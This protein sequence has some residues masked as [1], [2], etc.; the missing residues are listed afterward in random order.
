M[1]GLTDAQEWRGHYLSLRASCGEIKQ[2]AR[3]TDV[4]PKATNNFRMSS[5]AR[6]ISHS[7]G[8]AP[9]SAR[10]FES[11]GVLLGLVRGSR[12]LM[13]SF[14]G[15]LGLPWNLQRKTLRPTGPSGHEE[16]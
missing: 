2:A 1:Y 5:C 11:I 16:L 4:I 9:A 8:W 6:T 15:N 7:K 10:L 12:F 3:L 13:R 14:V